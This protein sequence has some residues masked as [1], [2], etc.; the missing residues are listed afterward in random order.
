MG[1]GCCCCR[2]KVVPLLPVPTVTETELVEPKVVPKDKPYGYV[3]LY[4]GK[5]CATVIYY[6][7]FL[8]S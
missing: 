8:N 3:R 1:N 6:I 2:K 4:A 7:L 5:I